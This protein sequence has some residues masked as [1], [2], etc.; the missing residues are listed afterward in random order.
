MPALAA[1]KRS[2][3]RVGLTRTHPRPQIRELTPFFYSDYFG[4]FTQA[5]NP[6]LKL[7]YINNADL[8]F[9]TFPTL[10]EDLAFRLFYKLFD[11]PIEPYY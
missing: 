10:R 7:T 8:R 4:A 2:N 11:A 1:S 9:E 3:L 5:G 6:D